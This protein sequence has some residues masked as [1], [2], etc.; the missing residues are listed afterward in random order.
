MTDFGSMK[1]LHSD[2]ITFYEEYYVPSLNN[3]IE[4]LSKI[5]NNKIKVWNNELLLD[6]LTKENYLNSCNHHI[7][8]SPFINNNKTLLL[9]NI[10]LENIKNLWIDN[11]NDF[12]YRNINIKKYFECW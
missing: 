4:Y 10:N 5:E 3:I 7:L 12:K 8:I 1:N 9:K 6:N 2:N 11:I